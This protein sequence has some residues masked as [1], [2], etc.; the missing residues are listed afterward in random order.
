MMKIF[1]TGGTGFIGQPLTKALIARGW[2][3]AALVRK[4]ESPQAR[5]LTRI[6]AQCVA[7]DITDRESMRVGMSGADIVVHNAGWYELG[8]TDSARKIMYAINVTGTENVLSLAFELGIPRTVYVST[9]AYYGDTGAEAGDETHR[10]QTPYRSYYEETKAEG[11]EIALQYQERGLQLITICPA[12]VVGPNDHSPYGYFQRMYVNGVMP[13]FIPSPDTVHAPMHVM[14]TAEG[15]A[16]AAEK[17]QLGETY[18]LAG[19]A[20]VRVSGARAALAGTPRVH[21]A[22]N[23]LE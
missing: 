11:H 4:P 17:G 10:R 14:D 12:Q 19:R 7:G 9:S 8:L 20:H 3:V 22:R 1:L 23:R 21:L 18:I 2:N 16:L 13:P 5:A 6:G 15:I